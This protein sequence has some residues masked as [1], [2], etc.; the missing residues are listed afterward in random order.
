MEEPIQDPFPRKEL[1][2]KETISTYHWTRRSPTEE[3]ITNLVP[4]ELWWKTYIES[5]VFIKDMHTEE[6]SK[7]DLPIFQDPCVM[8]M[9]RFFLEHDVFSDNPEASKQEDIDS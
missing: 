2:E 5:C 6:S 8:I 4:M 3:I 7:M 1:N 9:E